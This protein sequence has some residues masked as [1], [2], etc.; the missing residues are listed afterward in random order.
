MTPHVYLWQS[1]IYD[2]PHMMV[3]REVMIMM[4]IHTTIITMI[5]IHTLMIMNILGAPEATYELNRAHRRT[6]PHN[7]ILQHTNMCIYIYIYIHTYIQLYSNTI[8]YTITYYDVPPGGAS[9]SAAPGRRTWTAGRTRR[10]QTCTMFI[11]VY[12]YMY[13]HVCIYIYIYVCVYVHLCIYIYI[14]THMRRP[15]TIIIMITTTIII[16]LL[17][18]LLLLS[19]NITIYMYQYRVRDGLF[20]GTFRGPLVMGRLIIKSLCPYLAL[21]SKLLN[22]ISKAK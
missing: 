21:F 5:T 2:S 9:S 8:Y 13:T 22:Y 6:I 16:I 15:Q 20:V 4:I 19:L 7:I 3:R 14:Y 10:P 17:L 11:Y 18:L 1:Y 12:M